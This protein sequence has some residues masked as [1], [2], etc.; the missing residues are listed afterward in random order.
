MAVVGITGGVGAGKS[1]VARF[2]AERSGVP[3]IDADQVCRELLQPGR[4]GWQA[5]NKILS[6]DFFLEDGQLD[7]PRL[8]DALFADQRLRQ[9][10][11]T[12]LHPLAKEEIRTRIAQGVGESWLVE[13]PLLFEAG[14]QNEFDR[15]VVVYAGTAVR[16]ARLCR[17]D[18]ISRQQAEA[19]LAAQWPLADKVQ[20]A[21]HVVDNSGPWGETSLQLIRLASLL[22]REK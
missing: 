22:W 12:V 13:V 1:S 10:L 18:N 4:A 21:D 11:D 6:R 19:M 8:R 20:R 15:I 7:R 14:W 3:L 17:R 2:L 9:E 16:L 5:L